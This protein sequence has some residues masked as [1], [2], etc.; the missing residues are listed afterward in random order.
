MNSYF[1]CGIGGSGMLPLALI[2]QSRGHQIA[3]SD[4]AHDQGRTPDKFDWLQKNGINLSPQD[5]SG[6]TASTT[7]L[8]VSGAVEETVPDVQKARTLGLPIVTRAQLLSQLNNEALTSICI[9]GTSGKSTTTGM[10][11]YLLHEFEEN[12]TVMNGGIF[13]NYSGDNPYCTALTGRP[14]LFVSEVDESDGSI[15]L[16]RPSVA[17]VTNISLDHKSLDEL[18]QLFGDFLAKS[19]AAVINADDAHVRAIASRCRGRV[20]SFGLDFPATRLTAENITLRNFGSESTIVDRVTGDRFKL[21]LQVPGRHNIANALAA[22]AVILALG[23]NMDKAC[24]L[25]GG[26]TGIKRRFELVG[27]TTNNITIIDD[28]GHNPDKIAATLSA[29]KAFPGRLLVMFQPH[30]FGP[31]RLMRKELVDSFANYLSGQDMLLMP[32]PYYAG[33]T[34]DRSVSSQHI[35]ADLK[36]RGVNAA[37]YADRASITA[38]L[39]A[40]AQPGDRLIIM[41]ARDDTLSDY[42]RD[43]LNRLSIAA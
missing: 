7:A 40:A 14:E 25:L 16:Y 36:A 9:G 29:L 37:V 5:G 34:V 24:L 3:G 17:V 8:V 23:L 43:L 13:R 42:A 39:I 15:A 11:G 1:L 6:P 4:R 32:E 30:G 38:P 31:L 27:Q 28:F 12:P 10:V 35:V 26:F 2:L 22:L 18:K 41:G 33:G 20:I 19:P 21:S